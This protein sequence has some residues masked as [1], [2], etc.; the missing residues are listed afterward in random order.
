MARVEI[1]EAVQ[2]TVGAAISGATVQVNV[3]GGAAA[4]LYAA[5]AGATTVGNPRTTDAAGRIE[6]WVDEGSYDLVVSKS[7]FTSYTQPFDASRGSH[8]KVVH[9]A[10]LNVQYPEYGAVGDN[11]NNDS[12]ALAA[13]VTACPTGGGIYFP[14]G[15]YRINSQLLIEKAIDVFG[16][17]PGSVIVPNV[18][19]ATDAVVFN[20]PTADLLYG[21]NMRDI[22][23]FG[24]ASCCRHGLVLRDL[25]RSNFD[26]VRVNVGTLASTGWG[27]SVEGCLINHFNFI[28]PGLNV[29]STSAA[30]GFASPANA[31]RL[32]GSATGY[33]PN[34]NWVNCEIDGLA[35][36]GLYVDGS[37]LG[38]GGNV[39]VT[40][41]YEGIAGKGIWF[42]NCR[43]FSV[44][45]AHLEGSTLDAGVNAL[46]IENSGNGEIGGAVFCA[47]K[48][49]LIN[50]HD[51]TLDGISTQHLAI[52]SASARIRRRRIDFLN[53]GAG[54]TDVDSSVT[55]RYEIPGWKAIPT[56]Q[57][58][59]G[60]H[61]GTPG[62]FIGIDGLVH[63]RGS[64]SGGTAT[65]GTL[66]F[67]MPAG[68]RPAT[69]QDSVVYS[70]GVGGV[71]I[72]TNGEVRILSA[73]TVDLNLDNISF[74]PA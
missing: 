49:D 71:R 64:I 51:V 1:S 14:Y 73:S 15:K 53:P 17:G 60:T 52:D 23:V 56:L 47:N 63:F 65:G 70:N 30:F 28:I 25:A 12:T 72:Y 29:N 22:A 9:E 59:W 62:Y 66:L 74:V 43:N 58:G 13:A 5:E 42:Y 33:P 48:I 36:D 55:T 21:V 46:R 6:A 7:G 32:V 31:I 61:L 39:W 11:S 50:S 45:D 4:T 26:R 40:G 34:A 18:G 24:G 2:N 69:D 37:L 8:T 20:S 41:T 27:V 67:T 16:D 44:H 3:R 10:P 57:N 35:G 38:P 68:V 54:S 19:T